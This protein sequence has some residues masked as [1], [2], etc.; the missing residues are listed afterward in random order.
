VLN[1]SGHPALAVPSGID[2]ATGMP[3][4]IQIVAA[5]WSDAL[6]FRAGQVVENAVG[7]MPGTGMPA[8]GAVA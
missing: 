5:A 2:P 4:S 6:T 7:V 1:L 8:Q 3:T